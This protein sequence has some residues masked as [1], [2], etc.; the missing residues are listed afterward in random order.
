MN[1][2]KTLTTYNKR[3]L[4]YCGK[5]CELYT[6]MGPY[7]NVYNSYSQKNNAGYGAYVFESN[8]PKAQKFNTLKESNENNKTHHAKVKTA[9]TTDECSLPKH[10]CACWS[11]E[12]QKKYCVETR[13]CLFHQHWDGNKCVKEGGN[14]DKDYV[15]TYQDGYCAWPEMTPNGWNYHG[16][17]PEEDSM[18]PVKGSANDVAAPY[19]PYPF[20]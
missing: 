18:I 20:G 13:G 16:C 19:L 15:D 2:F 6:N 8:C 17:G 7:N 9:T 10:F 1:S 11:A 5:E 4:N 12:G 3:P 14:P